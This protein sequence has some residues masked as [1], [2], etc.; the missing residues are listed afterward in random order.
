MRLGSTTHAHPA[1]ARLSEYGRC[2]GTS[3][4]RGSWAPVCC[5]RDTRRARS[6]GREFVK[7]RYGAPRAQTDATRHLLQLQHVV[8]QKYQDGVVGRVR[9]PPAAI[10]AGP[11]D[12]PDTA[13]TSQGIRLVGFRHHSDAHAVTVAGCEQRH[14][15]HSSCPT[16]VRRELVRGH[17]GARFRTQQAHTVYLSTTKE[18]AGE[19]K[20]VVQRRPETLTSRLEGHVVRPFRERVLAG[21]RRQR[22]QVP[23]ASNPHRPARR[24]RFSRGTTKPVSR[25]PSG[26]QMRRSRT[27]P[28]DTPS[29][30]AM[31]NPSRSVDSP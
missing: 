25:M 30:R 23:S 18:D 4:G 11:S 12:S 14:A 15:Q 27:R 21:R 2:Q 3:T 10:R 1:I 28:R 5:W 16:L 9:L 20:I 29:R 7:L 13:A 26:L 8:R 6:C 24:V 17:H 31:R 22:G 19:G